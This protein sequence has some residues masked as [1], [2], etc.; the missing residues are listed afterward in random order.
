MAKVYVRG[1]YR[2]VSGKKPSRRPNSSKSG[3]SGA[4]AFHIC[5]M[6]MF[7]WGPPLIKL[8][9]IFYKAVFKY[10]LIF[11]KFV[12]VYIVK[13]YKWLFVAAVAACKKISEAI[14]ARKEKPAKIETEVET[15]VEEENDRNN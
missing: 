11:C 12:F 13:F 15:E 7:I 2:N 14:A 6:G 3:C 5:T 1:H 8:L 10:T 9:F 4:T